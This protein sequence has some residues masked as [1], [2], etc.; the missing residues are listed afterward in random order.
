MMMIEEQALYFKI[1]AKENDKKRKKGLL[2]YKLNR[3]NEN[4]IERIIITNNDNDNFYVIYDNINEVYA[5]N[6]L[7]YYYPNDEN[8]I[9]FQLRQSF[10]TKCYEI[11]KPIIKCNQMKKDADYIEDLNNKF[12]YKIKS[13]Y[14]LSE[15][16]DEDYCLNENDIIKLGEIKYEVIKIKINKADDTFID[17][18]DINNYNI[19]EINKKA[20]PIFKNDLSKENYIVSLNN[21]YI[22]GKNSY[23]ESEDK[24]CWICFDIDPTTIDNPKINIC[25]CKNRF[26]HY[27]CNKSFLKAKLTIHENLGH[28][29]LS[30]NS[31]E[32]NCNICLTP[33]PTRFKISEFN[34]T[35]ELIDLNL[36]EESNYI[37]L[38]SLD[39]KKGI[40]YIKKIHVIKLNDKEIYIGRKIINDVIIDEPTVSR[41]HAVLK[42]NENEG[43]VILENISKTYGTL[44]LIKGNIKMKNKN[45]YLQIGNLFITVNLI[46][47][48]L[49]Q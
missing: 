27:L 41:Y 25:K 13:N 40:N 43:K 4:I 5:I 7:L 6:S 30:Y 42:Y 29:V 26:V 46:P 15:E 2:Y 16:N 1:R 10:K 21:E 28:T 3:K 37:I 32:F 20:G 24:L 18:I 19:S 22:E 34:K 48:E 9:L 11:I 47:R 35:Y 23:S 8:Q 33:Y 31:N 45:L 44:V 49:I 14:Y 17:F 36:L 39:Y 12:W 38:E